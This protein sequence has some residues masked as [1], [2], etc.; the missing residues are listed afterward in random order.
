MKKVTVIIP[1]YNVAEYIEE[2]L[3]SVRA[4]GSVVDVVHCVDNGSSDNT[5]EK[6]ATW[7][8][9]NPEVRVSVEHEPYRG[10]SAARNRPLP[11]VTT[12]WVQFLDADDLLL[13]G[14][15][16]E[17]L[18]RSEG[19]DVLYESA[20]FVGTDGIKRLN[21][22]DDVVEVGLMSGELGNTC[23]NLWATAKLNDVQGWDRNLTSSQEYDLMLR[24]Y[25]AGAR[26]RKLDGVR[27]EVRER[28]SGRISQG[29]PRKRWRNMVEVQ[30]RMLITFTRTVH[31]P[32]RMD[33]IRQAFFGGLRTLYPYDPA[34]VTS[35]WKRHLQPVDFVPRQSRINT[36]SY[37]WAYRIFGFQSTER[38]KLRLDR[39]R[40]K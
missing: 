37:V 24:L 15:I 40:T 7:R 13:P 11:T 2:C 27:T 3:D 1:C 23:T 38:L 29:D 26:F 10:A 36:K 22:P 32:G 34:Y 8:S 16:A 35:L 12:E 19:A 31:D 20:M 9:A 14:K 6:I 30:E 4:Q 25:Q 39:M 21:T 18:A 28:I 5:L 33:R 17:Q